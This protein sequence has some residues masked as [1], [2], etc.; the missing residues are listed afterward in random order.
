MNL[1]F[2]DNLCVIAVKNDAKFER[3]IHLLFQALTNFDPCT[4]KSQKICTLIGF[5]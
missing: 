5:F 4:Q 2:T 1:N 3:R